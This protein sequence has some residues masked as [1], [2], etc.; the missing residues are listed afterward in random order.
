[1]EY[2]LTILFNV[3]TG[4]TEVTVTTEF[5]ELIYIAKDYCM[6]HKRV[7]GIRLILK[8]TFFWIVLGHSIFWSNCGNISKDNAA[9]IFMAEVGGSRFL[10]NCDIYPPDSTASHLP[11]GAS[12]LISVYFGIYF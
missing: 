11:M 2:S 1:M 5:K 6:F 12:N 4:D 3:G 7:E 8:I 10:R 9:S